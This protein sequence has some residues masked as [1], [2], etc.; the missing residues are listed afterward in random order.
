MSIQ[1]AAFRWKKF[2]VVLPYCKNLAFVPVE[3]R[4]IQYSNTA[5][6]FN[7]KAKR[8]GYNL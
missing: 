7:F 6:T 4:P 8:D 1:E 5:V 2:C 3:S